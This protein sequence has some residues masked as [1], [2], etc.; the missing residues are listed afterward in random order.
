MPVEIVHAADEHDEADVIV[1][2][3]KDAFKALPAPRRWSDIAVL[4]RRHRHRELIVDRLRKQDIPYVV[5]GG[6]GLFDV[7]EVRDVEAALRVAAN[8]DDSNA[9]VRLLSAGPWRLDAAEILRVT[10]AAAWDGRP[11][12]Q[13]A[14]DI[15]REH[16]VG[17]SNGSSAPPAVHAAPV[18][19]R[20]PTL[21]DE[22]G[23]R[24]ERGAERFATGAPASN[25]R[26][27]AARSWMRA[28]APSSSE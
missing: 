11:V 21:W 13:A 20:L 5:I 22:G 7:P 25:V 19:D 2:W 14:S 4:Y 6:T 15:L 28:S 26:S 3:I 23:V 24:R 10:N 16:R 1:N 27:N 8:P 12:H 18:M 9:F 17:G